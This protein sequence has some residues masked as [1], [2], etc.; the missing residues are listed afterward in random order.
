MIIMELEKQSV[1]ILKEHENHN[2]VV[3]TQSN[4]TLT[5]SCMDCREIIGIIIEEDK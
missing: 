3:R 1:E 5:L 2:I 4:G